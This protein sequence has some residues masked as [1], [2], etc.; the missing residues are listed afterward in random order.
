[1]TRNASP[2]LAPRDL[3]TSALA[4]DAGAYRRRLY[5]GGTRRHSS[6]TSVHKLLVGA[7]SAWEESPHPE[8]PRRARRVMRKQAAHR[9][10]ARSMIWRPSGD[11][12]IALATL[13]STFWIF[14]PTVV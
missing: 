14:W 4:R 11:Q 12:F 13:P 7:Y 9:W 1:M 5:R 6:V 3:Q 8:E 10:T 2:P